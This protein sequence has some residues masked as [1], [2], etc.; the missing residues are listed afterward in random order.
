M[1]NGEKQAML[2]TLSERVIRA[3]PPAFLML[4]LINLAFL[5]AMVWFLNHNVSSRNEMLSKIIDRCL[6]R[7]DSEQSPSK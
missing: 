6:L 1:T 5:A 2:V 4:A 3:L 7:I